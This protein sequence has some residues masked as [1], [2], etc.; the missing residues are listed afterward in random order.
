M[1]DAL[2]T[3]LPAVLVTICLAISITVVVVGAQELYRIRLRDRMAIELLRLVT[4][5]SDAES[6]R[7]IYDIVDEMLFWRERKRL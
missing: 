7:D 1:S 3:V 5:K 6:I 2:L 4:S